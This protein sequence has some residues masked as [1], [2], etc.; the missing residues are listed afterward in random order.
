M[1]RDAHL[2]DRD[3]NPLGGGEAL[4]QLLGDRGRVRLQQ[5]HRTFGERFGRDADNLR[6]VGGLRELV[7]GG[8]APPR[9]L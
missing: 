4:A 6:V 3:P 9:E 2:G 5:A 7:G 8:E 1:D